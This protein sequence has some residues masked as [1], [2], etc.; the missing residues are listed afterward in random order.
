MVTYT[1]KNKAKTDFEKIMYSK[2]GRGYGMNRVL[3]NNKIRVTVSDFG[4]ELVG[5]WDKK[6]G[7]ERIWKA[8]AAVWA[9]HAPILFPFVG[10]V[11]G[12]KYRY[13]GKEYSMTSHGFARD[14]QFEFVCEDGLSVTHVLRWNEESLDIYPFK[15]SL[16]VK[17]SL[18]NED[19]NSVRIEWRVVNEDSENGET[20]VYGIGGHP[21]FTFPGGERAEDCS[22]RIYKDVKSK[23]D[24]VLKYYLLDASGCI[25]MSEQYSLHLN[26]G[27]IK[28][29]QN[30]FDRDAFIVLDN[31]INHIELLDASGNAYVSMDCEGFP[32][33]GIWSKNVDEFI[34]LEPWYGIADMVGHDGDI[35]NKTGMQRL[36]A[37]E[38]RSYV[39]T[40]GFNN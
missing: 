38:S 26:S 37:R 5:V 17:H 27:C 13:K 31:Q 24:G 32:Y 4:A 39:Y 30:M 14:R 18:E 21:A 28:I 15:F 2:N 12:G 11:A 20:M 40:V 7:V 6:R 34:C 23:E 25:D 16:Y 33:F 36:G 10:K 29:T 1:L 8:D 22:L 19:S 9:R 35:E 3:E